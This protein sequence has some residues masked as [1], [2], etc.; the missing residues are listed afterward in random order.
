MRIDASELAALPNVRMIGEVPYRELP[1]YLHGFDVCLLPYRVCECALASDPTKLW[2]DM[3]AGKPVVAV[4]FPEVERLHELITLT[5][6]RTEFVEGIRRGI[7]ENDPVLRER[8]IAY[9]RENSWKAAPPNCMSQQRL[10]SPRSALLSFATISV[11]SRRRVSTVSS[12]SH[13]T[14]TW[15]PLL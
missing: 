5:S 8:R 2:K 7:V 1:A 12:D 9:A 11:R 3:S 15:K 4:R 10:T 13:V 6:T 14:R